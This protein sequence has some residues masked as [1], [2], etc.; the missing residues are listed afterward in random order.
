MKIE[1][2]GGESISRNGSFPDSVVA[3]PS[4]ALRAMADKSVA[5]PPLALLA[6]WTRIESLVQKRTTLCLADESSRS[7]GAFFQKQISSGNPKNF[8][9]RLRKIASNPNQP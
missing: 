7:S 5:G 9:D 3:R 8:P 1:P 2:L 6:P 4:P